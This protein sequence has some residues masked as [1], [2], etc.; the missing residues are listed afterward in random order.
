MTKD[1]YFV[2]S[3]S[4]IDE[5]VTIGDG[6]KVWHFFRIQSGAVIGARCAIEQ[7]V[8]I[9]NNVFSG[10]NVKI[11][12]NVSVY[13]GTEIEDDV[14][15][16]PSCVLTNVTNPRSQA[17]RH[18]LYQRTLLRPRRVGWCQR[19]DCVRDTVEVRVHRR[20]RGGDQRCAGLRPHRWRL[21]A[22]FLAG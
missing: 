3:S 14:F 13:E 18:S 12:N 20:R 19:H 9:G 7:N 6:T 1:G 15:L 5:H 17:F 16:G 11:Q 2:H 21:P 10:S 22:G 4:F 8:N